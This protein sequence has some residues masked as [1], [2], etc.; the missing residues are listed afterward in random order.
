[1][2][3][4]LQGSPWWTMSAIGMV[5]RLS[6]HSVPHPTPYW[7]CRS[8][9]R[10]T[11]GSPGQKPLLTP[12]RLRHCELSHNTAGPSGNRQGNP[13]GRP[14]GNRQGMG[15]A[16]PVCRREPSAVAASKDL[17]VNVLHSASSFHRHVSEY[18][19]SGCTSLQAFIKPLLCAFWG[20]VRQIAFSPLYTP[21]LHYSLGC[22]V[23]DC[24]P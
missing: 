23:F 9:W 22:R 19:S 4:E 15:Q 10:R 21:Y 3:F 5:L 17:Q 1:M 18:F 16:G 24:Q 7:A 20:R 11:A 13:G 14:S 12:I 2:P 6:H 8:C